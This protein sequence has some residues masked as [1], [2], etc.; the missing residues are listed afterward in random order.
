MSRRHQ[1]GCISSS[2]RKRGQVWEFRWREISQNGTRKQRCIVIGSKKQFPTEKQAL[3]EVEHLRLKLNRGAVSDDPLPTFRGLA[4]HY[5]ENE[6]S[7]GRTGKTQKTYRCYLS[8]WILP[9]W[10]K[11]K[12]HGIKSIGVESWL[13][14]LKLAN[15]SRAKIRNI[16]SSIFRHGLRHEL[17]QSNPITLV[18]QSAKRERTPVI[19]TVEELRRLFAALNQREL[20][21]ILVD[22]FTGLRMGELIGLKWEDIDFKGMNIHVRRS[23]VDQEVT[24][25]K[26]E[27][28]IKPVPMPDCIAKELL[29]WYR[30]STY[31]QP[32]DWVFASP[33]AKGTLP[34][35]PQ[36]LMRYFIKPAAARVGITKKIGWHT[37]RH[38][39]ST[40]VKSLGVD[41]KVV[42]GLL[43]HASFKTTMDVYTQEMDEPKRAAQS[44]LVKAILNNK[45]LVTKM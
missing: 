45:K 4:Q 15:G 25:G 31:T 42:Q 3:A 9:E 30:E 1:D 21:L 14:G 26:T 24:E 11:T 41:A 19:L 39:F 35:W 18:R 44:R 33:H 17:V 37:F 8:E 43:R 27:A 7:L 29:G 23:V 20:V 36:T 5:I 10:G 22:A 32:G 34:Y 40:L 28:S 13:R 38:T 6:L 2:K 12:V 16:M